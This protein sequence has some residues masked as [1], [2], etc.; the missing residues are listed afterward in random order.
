MLVFF[1]IF[2]ITARSSSLA[3]SRFPES[4]KQEG[5]TSLGV[6]LAAL[7]SVPTK[8][9]SPQP[10]LEHSPQWGRDP[11]SPGLSSRGRRQM[12]CK[13][14]T[15]QAL[16]SGNSHVLFRN[17]RSRQYDPSCPPTAETHPPTHTHTSH[18]LQP[19]CLLLLCC[20][21]QTLP[22]SLKI[23]LNFTQMRL[24][25]FLLHILV[26]TTESWSFIIQAD[27]CLFY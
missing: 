20:L 22:P 25:Q 21:F 2:F 18:C 3:C 14:C 9:A 7:L 19:E 4:R 8:A 16:H 15:G 13:P 24:S 27:A 5:N 17:S 11:L 12:V 26:S 1:Q 10:G 6:S 23:R